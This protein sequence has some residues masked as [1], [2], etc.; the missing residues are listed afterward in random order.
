MLRTWLTIG[1]AL[2]LAGPA[3]PS[4]E[5][6]PDL[7]AVF[8]VAR[9]GEFRVR[10]Y[11]DE[12]PNH[13]ANFLTLAA[14][15]FY[16]GMSFHRVIPGFLVQAGDPS[17]RDEDPDNDGAGGPGYSLPPEPTERSHTRGT[18]SMAWREDRPGTAG[19]QWFIALSDLPALDGRATP[20]G[21]VVA[22]MD[23]VDRISQA[24]T[25]R[26]RNPLERLVIESVRLE[27][28][29]EGQPSAGG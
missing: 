23:V 29:A 19:S 25:R 21:R 22:G 26:N 24:P 20:I 11:R 7:D 2:L 6:V 9:F 8:S 28:A 16:D 14:D 13:V 18:F 27:P 4:P 12:V 3:P 1:L 5:D 10:F 17:S 15:G